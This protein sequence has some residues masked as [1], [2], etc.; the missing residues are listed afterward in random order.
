M[1]QKFN[2]SHA[3]TKLE[4]TFVADDSM[5]EL[6]PDVYKD[7]DYA[8]GL[9]SSRLNKIW[10]NKDSANYFDTFMHELGEYARQEVQSEITHEQMSAIVKILTQILT[11]NW[12]RIKTVFSMGG[13]N[14][15]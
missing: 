4:V 10:I 12:S 8:L 11:Q 9:Y 6:A 7:G 2:L 1:N 15:S 3:G 13:N 14:G 5:R